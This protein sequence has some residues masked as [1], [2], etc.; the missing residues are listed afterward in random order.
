MAKRPLLL[1]IL[2]GFGWVPG[3]TYGNAI[4]AAKTPNLDKLFASCPYTTIGASGMDVGLPD[5]QMG[6]SEV[7]HTNIGAG[8][9]VYQAVSYTHLVFLCAVVKK[10]SCRH[11]LKKP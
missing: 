3:E 9:I 7:G 2:D 8:R 4:V 11:L 1:C 5:G 6:N 10:L